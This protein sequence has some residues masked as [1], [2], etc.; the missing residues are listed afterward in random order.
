MTLP[1]HS[2]SLGP[3]PSGS[4]LSFQKRRSSQQTDV[5]RCWYIGCAQKM[6]WAQIVSCTLFSALPLGLVSVAVICST[7]QDPGHI[8]CLF[9]H[10]SSPIHLSLLLL[11][12]LLLLS[13]PHESHSLVS[14]LH[15]KVSYALV[16]VC[17]SS[18]ASWC[19]TLLS[20]YA[21]LALL[22]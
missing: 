3:V 7:S 4:G 22:G 18:L 15:L 2:Q 17:A 6:S 16:K 11:C 20:L 10:S 5:I 13:P 21:C 8:C 12:L 1:S 14:W 9:S 19:Q